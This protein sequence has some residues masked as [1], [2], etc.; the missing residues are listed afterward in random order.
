MGGMLSSPPGLFSVFKRGPLKA[1]SSSI[2]GRGQFGLVST[3][4]GG[5]EQRNFRT[6]ALLMFAWGEERVFLSAGELTRRAVVPM[7]QW[8]D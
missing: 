4:E 5:T 7:D 1:I 3:R 8:R 6:R 2:S